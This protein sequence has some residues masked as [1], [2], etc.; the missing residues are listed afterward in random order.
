MVDGVLLLV[1]ASRGS[2][3]S[4]RFVLRKALER[5]L[6]CGARGQQD[7]PADARPKEVVDEVYE[8]FLDLDADEEQIEFP[9]VYCNAR[10]GRASPSIRQW[11]GTD[12]EPLFKVIYDYIPAPTFE[13]GHPLQAL[14]TNLDGVGLWSVVLRS[15]V[16]CMARS[17]AVKQVAWCRADGAVKR[18]KVARAVRVRG[19]DRVDAAEA[20]PGRDHC[21]GRV[22]RCHDRRDALGPRRPA[23]RFPVLIVDEPS[24]GMNDRHQHLAPVGDRRDQGHRQ[25]A[26]EPPRR[27][28]CR[29]RLDPHADHRATPIPGGARSR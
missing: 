3:A 9:I 27:R 4:D 29:Q 5:R 13:P 24:L 21:R 15:A 19:L 2:F 11:L 12:L 16:C 22:V 23:G 17:G 25:A 20:G 18:F 26:Q 28:A 7:R 6:P 10:A 14:V 8:L 1:D